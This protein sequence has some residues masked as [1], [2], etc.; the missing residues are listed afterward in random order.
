MEFIT[1]LFMKNGFNLLFLLYLL[2]LTSCN[3]NHDT[4]LTDAVTITDELALK[5]SSA[6]ERPFSLPNPKVSDSSKFYFFIE[7]EAGVVDYQ[8]YD[9]IQKTWRPHPSLFQLSFIGGPLQTGRIIYQQALWRDSSR[10]LLLGKE[11]KRGMVLEVMPLAEIA[12]NNDP[13]QSIFIMVPVESAHRLSDCNHFDDWF[14]HCNQHRFFV[15][16]WIE[17]QFAPR[18][19]HRIQWKPFR[20]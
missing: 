19:I 4:S 20:F 9:F 6:A 15:Q 12:V 16:F 7:N 18:Y 8:R 14:T 5:D 13:T 1:F 10:Y 11:L 3:S 2:G 17:H